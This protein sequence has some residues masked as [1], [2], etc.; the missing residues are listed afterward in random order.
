MKRLMRLTLWLYPDAWRR[1]YGAEV[2]RLIDDG[3][4]RPVDLVDLIAR[5]PLGATLRG[6]VSMLNRQLSAHPIRLALVALAI[7]F[8]TAILVGVAVLKYLLDVPGPFD[9]IEPS[10]TPFV[11]HPIG[12]MIL[13]MAPY[14]AFALAILPFARLRLESRDARLAA[15]AQAAVPLACL[16]VGAVSAVLIVFMGLYWMAEN[17]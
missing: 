13:V 7:T 4:A 2:R 11:T 5:A 3:R 12:E 15:S 16:L 14:L 8:P 1:R 6:E 9:T 10:V 17:L